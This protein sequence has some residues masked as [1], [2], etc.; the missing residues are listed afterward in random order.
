MTPVPGCSPLLK[1]PAMWM[2]PNQQKAT[3]KSFTLSGWSNLPGKS[4]LFDQLAKLKKKGQS[5]KPLNQL[6]QAKIDLNCNY[7]VPTVV[8]P[9]SVSR[10]PEWLN[11]VV[12]QQKSV[13]F[14]LPPTKKPVSNDVINVVKQQ[15]QK[16]HHVTPSRVSFITTEISDSQESSSAEVESDFWDLRYQQKKSEANWAQ[17]QCCYQQQQQQQQYCHSCCCH[18]SLTRLAPR[19]PPVVHHHQQALISVRGPR[20]ILPDY[21][22][23]DADDEGQLIAKTSSYPS[24]S[25]TLPKKKG[26]SSQPYSASGAYKADRVSTKSIES[27]PKLNEIGKK[28][29]FMVE[30]AFKP[31]SAFKTGSAILKPGSTSVEIPPSH[32]QSALKAGNSALSSEDSAFK[33]TASASKSAASASSKSAASASSKS[34]SKSES[35]S[36]SSSDDANSPKKGLNES[37]ESDP[38]YESDST[39]KKCLQV[40]T[41]KE[42]G[43]P[44]RAATLPRRSAVVQKGPIS[45]DRRKVSQQNLAESEAGVIVEIISP[46]R[47]SKKNMSRK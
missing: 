37:G 45:L 15:Q 46:V 34:G 25:M 35:A 13:R 7:C 18:Q 32:T 30:S 12:E 19:R 43:G 10:A 38:G 9:K 4:A 21:T 23:D 26:S 14:T 1:G 42:A 36:S 41:T 6:Q 17:P 33:S 11:H 29:S 24:G 28:K 22:D 3:H 31:G 44:N 20:E 5:K 8:A 40:P 27:A 47:V 16:Q 2:H 39:G